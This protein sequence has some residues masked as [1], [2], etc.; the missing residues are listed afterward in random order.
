MADK[1]TFE[2]K[3]E[4]R[5]LQVGPCLV[6][7]ME[8]DTPFQDQLW[9]QWLE[10]VAQPTT[11]S[12]MICAWGATE[13][14][15]QQWRRANRQMRDQQL[16]VAVVTEARH[17]A[18]LAKAASWLGTN[19][20]S[21]RWGD[22]HAACEFVGYDRADRIGARAKITALRDR[23]GTVTKDET[24]APSYMSAPRPADTTNNTIRA[25]GEL[26]RE[27]N[28][29]IQARLAEVQERLRNRAAFSRPDRTVD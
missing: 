22:L 24:S 14:S 15:N 26:V 17:N 27:T 9:D 29:E 25:S 5:W 4:L 1:V 6:T 19:I 16:A 10:A 23:F 20:V 3:R 7:Y 21:Y 13:P 18:A 8:A 2:G 12:L 11:Q 28:D